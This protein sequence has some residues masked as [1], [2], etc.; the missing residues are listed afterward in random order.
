MPAK[1]KPRGAILVRVEEA[2][3]E[4][5]DELRARLKGNPSRPDILRHLLDSYL[6]QVE[7]RPRA[8]RT[9]A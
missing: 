2:Q 6:N 3:L 8:N 4:R 7:N 1:P 5:L 9:A